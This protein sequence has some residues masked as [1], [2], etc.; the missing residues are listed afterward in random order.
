MHRRIEGESDMNDKWWRSGMACA[1]YVASVF[2]SVAPAA[3][4]VCS[5][6]V[7]Q[8]AWHANTGVLLQLDSMNTSVVICDPSATWTVTGTTLVTTADQC[9]MLLSMFLAAKLAGRPLVSVYF[10]GD[11]VPTSCTTWTN[12][13]RANLRYF[14]WAD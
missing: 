1:L 5:G 9:K 12:W 2:A 3:T 11:S 13:S 10:D 6:Q 8:I 4:V 7:T 14:A